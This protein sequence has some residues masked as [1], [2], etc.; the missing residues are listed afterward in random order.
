MANMKIAESFSHS[1]D[2]EIIQA[3]W[4]F[5]LVIPNFMRRLMDWF[6]WP[7][8]LFTWPVIWVENV[9]SN[10]LGWPITLLTSLV[11]FFPNTLIDLGTLILNLPGILLGGTGFSFLAGFTYFFEWVGETTGQI[12]W[13]PPVLAWEEPL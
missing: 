7:L 9:Y 13:V 2:V 12:T 8:Y 5:N 4:P 3:L 1:H 10:I 6:T 11:M